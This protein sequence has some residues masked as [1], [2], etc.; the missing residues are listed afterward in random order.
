MLL[1]RARGCCRYMRTMVKCSTCCGNSSSKPL[2]YLYC[3]GLHAEATRDGKGT[4]PYVD[5]DEDRKLLERLQRDQLDVGDHR[6]ALKIKKKY[7]KLLR[8]YHPD[9]YINEKNEQRR[10]QKEEIFLHIYRH[11]NSF[12]EQYDD[13]LYKADY[14]DE[15]V[16]ETE[17]D[18]EERLERYRRYSEGKRNDVSHF[19]KNV[20]IYIL[21]IILVTFGGV[22]LVCVYLP[23]DVNTRREE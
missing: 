11:Y 23:F 12:T 21:V 10:K 4:R 15:S 16:C 13:H 22:L 14:T 3:R 5:Y 6:D 9:T 20:E 1:S 19:H 2:F 8:L 17:Q 7:L 18:R